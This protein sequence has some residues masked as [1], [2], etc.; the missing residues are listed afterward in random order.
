ME[1]RVEQLRIATWKQMTDPAYFTSTFF[2][3][4][5]K[6]VAPLDSYTEQ[7]TVSAW[8]VTSTGATFVVEKSESAPAQLLQR[9]GDVAAERLAKVDMR[10]TWIGKDH[11][12]RVRE[13][14]TIVSNGGLSR[15]N[16]PAMGSAA[17][18]PPVPTAA[19]TP[20]PTS[21]PATPAPT[22]PVPPTGNGNGRGNV[23]GK[24]G[25]A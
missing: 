3:L 18:S 9:R 23:G 17:G 12:E 25:K 10:V 20:D 22:T 6:S 21:P 19:A 16:L 1:E 11:R 2:A 7:V 14:S 15:M 8:P 5:P 13:L 4:R 24:S